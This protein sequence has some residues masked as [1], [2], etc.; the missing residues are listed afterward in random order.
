LFNVD[1]AGLIGVGLLNPVHRVQIRNSAFFSVGMQIDGTSVSYLNLEGIVG[2]IINFQNSGGALP[3]QIQGTVGVGGI[4]RVTDNF[5]VNNFFNNVA[6]L[7]AAN[8]DTYPNWVMGLQTGSAF[9]A[10]TR[11]KIVS[12][13]SLS[14]DFALK[15]QN[16]IGGDLLSV[17]NDGKAFL[18][19]KEISVTN[20]TINYNSNSNLGVGLNTTN[21]FVRGGAIVNNTDSIANG[22]RVIVNKNGFVSLLVAK[23]VTA[24][25]GLAT[26]TFTVFLNGVATLLTFTISGATLVGSD[27]VTRIAVVLGDELSVAVINGAVAPA[28]SGGAI[29]SFSIEG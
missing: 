1:N 28:N 26:R 8:V 24:P 18:G 10:N 2:G 14:T 13:N 23:L 21:F 11:F 17:R 25:T 20:S 9:D 6:I 3:L 5:A 4:L 15:T 27:T 19:A 16:S 22:T 12:Q 7:R 29:I